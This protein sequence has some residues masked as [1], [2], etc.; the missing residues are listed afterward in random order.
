M[1]AGMLLFLLPMP[2]LAGWQMATPGGNAAANS[3]D[4]FFQSA[5]Q[6][7]V[8]KKESWKQTAIHPVHGHTVRHAVR[9]PSVSYAMHGH[10]HAVRHSHSHT[11]PP[12]TEA[13]VKP[14]SV[15]KRTMA[16]QSVWQQ[17]AN[18]QAARNSF[19]GMVR[20]VH[21]VAGYAIS[22]SGS[23]RDNVSRIM[24]RYHWK[25]IWQSPHDFNF[26]G[27]LTGTSLPD[28]IGRLFDPFPLQAKMYM[29]NRTM[30][31]IPRE[32]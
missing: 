2:G 17:S 32:A 26:D 23:L 6:T 13:A 8:V 3:R 4:P 9:V 5:G 30:V 24:H 7:V 1:V 20:Q 18:R 10:R 25:V 27:R 15:W 11:H 21:P 19:S 14:V 16:Q 31:V 29:S 12:Q 22:M 28:V